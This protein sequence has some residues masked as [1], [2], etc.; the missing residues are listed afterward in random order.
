M[1]VFLVA[2]YE[3]DYGD[4]DVMYLIRAGELRRAVEIAEACQRTLP[5]PDFHV[6]AASWVVCVG[7]ADATSEELIIQGPYR[8]LAS[9]RGIKSENIWVRQRADSK[10]PWVNAKEAEGDDGARS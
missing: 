10:E 5:V 3:A 2:F 7:D 8:H 9:A 6:T 1:K 4:E